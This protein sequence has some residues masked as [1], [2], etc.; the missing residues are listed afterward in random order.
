VVGAA[1]LFLAE[2]IKGGTVPGMPFVLCNSPTTFQ[3][4]PKN[5]VRDCRNILFTSYLNNFAS[6]LSQISPT[7]APSQK[8]DVVTPEIL[9]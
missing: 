7:Y 6:K 5:F 3:T 4:L 9:P 8:I 1:W 2:V